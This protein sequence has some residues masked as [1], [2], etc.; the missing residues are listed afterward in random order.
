MMNLRA[1][2]QG[3]EGSL[4]GGAFEGL[5]PQRRIICFS[6][7]LREQALCINKDTVCLL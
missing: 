6:V 5:Q 3:N 2:S 7:G 4:N 1:Q